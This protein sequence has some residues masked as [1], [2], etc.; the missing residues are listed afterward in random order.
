MQKNEIESLIEEQNICRIAF[1]GDKYPYLAPFLY[2]YHEG[3]LYFHFT[4]YGKK[5]KL[6]GKDGRVCVGI[7]KLEPDMKHYEFVVL[8]GV[9][10]MVKDIKERSKAIQLMAKKSKEQLSENFLAAHGFDR[11]MGWSALSPENPMVIVKL[12]DIKDTVGLKSPY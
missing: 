4:D 12:N 9:L 5:M 7:E 3:A 1:K 8:S 6:M 10:E 2:I 11:E